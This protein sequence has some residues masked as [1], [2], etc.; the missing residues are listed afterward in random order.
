MITFKS[1]V[2][3]AANDNAFAIFPSNN[4]APETDRMRNT[5]IFGFKDGASFGFQLAIDTLRE[6]DLAYHSGEVWANCLEGKMKE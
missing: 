3:Q 4:I 6:F 5:K 1:K 2:E